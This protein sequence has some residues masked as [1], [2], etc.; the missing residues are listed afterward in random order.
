MDQS[1]CIKQYR[2]CAKTTKDRFTTA[3]PARLEV[4][5]ARASEGRIPRQQDE[6]WYDAPVGCHSMNEGCFRKKYNNNWA[7]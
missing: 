3:D 2:F 7:D 4:L 1:K 5:L 6:F